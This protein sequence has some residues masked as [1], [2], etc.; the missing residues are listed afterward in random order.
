MP[1]L[2]RLAGAAAL[3]TAAAAGTALAG[4][5]PSSGDNPFAGRYSSGSASTYLM[6]ISIARDGALSGKLTWNLG[7]GGGWFRG[8]RAAGGREAIATRYTATYAGTVSTDGRMLA[9]ATTSS[10]TSD[11]NGWV[12]LTSND[13]L[14]IQPDGGATPIVLPRR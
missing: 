2:L 9:T 3:L 11:W 14:V 1:T 5:P 8:G 6:E 13:E 10:G 4:K 12:S 7:G